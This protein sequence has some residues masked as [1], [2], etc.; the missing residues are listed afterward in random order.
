MSE[1]N[2]PVSQVP[3]VRVLN[4]K[5]T[6]SFV[7]VTLLVDTIILST[8]SF[9]VWSVGGYFRFSF[10]LFAILTALVLPPALWACVKV[11]LLAFDA[12]TAPENN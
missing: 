11:A 4:L 8:S 7:S 2:A 9:L 6:L 3:T 5:S 10:L 1:R 12:E